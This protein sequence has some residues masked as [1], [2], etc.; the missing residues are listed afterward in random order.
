[1]LKTSVNMAARELLR[2]Y[3]QDSRCLTSKGICCIHSGP[4]LYRIFCINTSKSVRSICWN[5]VAVYMVD[6]RG[7]D[8]HKNITVCFQISASQANLLDEEGTCK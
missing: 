4:F 7:L 6:R 2:M 1:M 8:Y 5:V 3:G